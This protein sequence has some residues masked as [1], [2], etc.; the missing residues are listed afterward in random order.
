M[1]TKFSRITEN[2]WEEVMVTQSLSTLP[3][4]WKHP[5]L[6]PV[7]VQL[8]I[9]A[10]LLLISYPPVTAVRAVSK[11]PGLDMITES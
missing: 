3:D 5:E 8:L 2:G 1:K 10:V 4:C 11:A 7:E 6:V 9:P